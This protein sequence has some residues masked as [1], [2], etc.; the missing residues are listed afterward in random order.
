MG[1]TVDM[2]VVIGARKTAKQLIKR[3][4]AAGLEI[5]REEQARSFVASCLDLRAEPACAK[6]EHAVELQAEK[7]SK[8][9]KVAVEGESVVEPRS[10]TPLS[11]SSKPPEGEQAIPEE[12]TSHPTLVSVELSR[13]S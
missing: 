11:S 2:F 4:E 10:P 13:H 1:Q 8:K 5:C 3:A 7:G 9:R 12:G 6:G